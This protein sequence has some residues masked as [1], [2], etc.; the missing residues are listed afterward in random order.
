MNNYI[1]SRRIH[2]QFLEAYPYIGVNIEP[3]QQ[4]LRE[5]LDHIQG[6]LLTPKELDLLKEYII[7]QGLEEYIDL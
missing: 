4:W 1:S 3:I 7:S 5:N 2:Q 6:P